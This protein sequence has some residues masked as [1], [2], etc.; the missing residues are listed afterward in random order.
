MIYLGIDPGLNGGMAMV[1]ESFI[2]TRPFTD[3]KSMLDW[4]RESPV[5]DFFATIEL[6]HSI[7]GSSAKS[8]FEFGKNLGEWIGL[9][10]AL[11][12]PYQMVPPQTWQKVMMPGKPARIKG[13]DPA[14]HKQA[15][16]DHAAKV[17]QALWPEHDFRRTPKCK[18]P[19]T[20]MVDA[21]LIAEYGRRIKNI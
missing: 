1:S 9:L 20:G 4:L 12:I 18:G 14:K 10:T 3:M 7:H 11:S 2:A 13:G 8:N 6:V 21:A 17:A 15:I 19:H 5:E 16:K